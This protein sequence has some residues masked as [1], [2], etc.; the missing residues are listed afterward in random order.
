[1]PQLEE[2]DAQ[3]L[4]DVAAGKTQSPRGTHPE[5]R[6]TSGSGFKLIEQYSTPAAS[7]AAIL[8][9]VPV[10]E[11]YSPE[12]RKSLV[13][14]HKRHVAL[15]QQIEAH[16]PQIAD[17]LIKARQEEYQR[18]PDD[19]NLAALQAAA[20]SRESIRVANSQL[21]S[22][23]HAARQKVAA[24]AAPTLE[25]IRRRIVEKVGKTLAEVEKAEQLFVQSFGI[26]S[27]ERG[28]AWKSVFNLMSGLSAD[29][30]YPTNW[31]AHSITKFILA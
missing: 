27:D 16:S 7:L 20:R 15:S 22:Q 29:P 9:D 19:E 8:R 2:N 1:M 12:E 5:L 26:E 21:R 11:I 28:P 10:S 3:E 17:K 14:L 30:I 31:T 18:N 23:I 24:E 4:L 13:G 6:M 25:E